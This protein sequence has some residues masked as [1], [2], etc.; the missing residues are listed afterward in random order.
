MVDT[1]KIREQVSFIKS[2]LDVFNKPELHKIICFY[3][4]ITELCNAYDG[5]R[6][7]LLTIVKEHLPNGSI[8]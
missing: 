5:I 3:D 2:N 4:S 8:D 6:Q 1:A 7:T